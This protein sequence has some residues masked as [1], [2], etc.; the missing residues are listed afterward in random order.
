MLF[1]AFGNVVMEAMASGLPVLVS[2]ACGAAE[3]LPMEMREFV[4]ADPANVGEIAARMN[5]LLAARKAL[6]AVARATA[7]QFTWERYGRQLLELLASL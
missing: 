6:S 7:E 5:G 1:E 3:T 4:V 2:S